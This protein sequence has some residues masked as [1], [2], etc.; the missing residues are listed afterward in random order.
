ME[1]YTNNPT[2]FQ[3][4]IGLPAD[5]EAI[6]ESRPENRPGGQAGPQPI[7]QGTYSRIELKQ[8]TRNVSFD[9]GGKA[10]RAA[11]FAGRRRGHPPLVAGGNLYCSDGRDLIIGVMTVGVGGRPPQ[12]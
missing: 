11:H 1:Q 8:W 4:R 7:F 9:H 12:L 5:Y 10:G 2:P 6:V 3:I